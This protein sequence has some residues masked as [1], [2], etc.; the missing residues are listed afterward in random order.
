[1]SLQHMSFIPHV[2]TKTFIHQ[3]DFLDNTQYVSPQS[4]AILLNSLEKNKKKNSVLTAQ[5]QKAGNDSGRKTGYPWSNISYVWKKCHCI[6]IDHKY[7][8]PWVWIWFLR[9]HF[10]TAEQL[11][12]LR[13][14]EL[15]EKVW[16][17]ALQ[18][19]FKVASQDDLIYLVYESWYLITQDT[20]ATGHI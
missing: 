9:Q 17:P 2:F 8:R 15:K 20:V 14:P 6:F 4:P 5:I 3:W 16:P 13:M 12:T 11:T 18:L 1:M 10:S 19:L 7:W